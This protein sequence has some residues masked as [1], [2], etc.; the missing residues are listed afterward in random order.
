[1]RR[2]RPVNR[3]S[4]PLAVFLLMLWLP[5]VLLSAGR[6]GGCGIEYDNGQTNFRA[7]AG[8]AGGSAA[9]AEG[10]ETPGRRRAAPRS[11]RPAGL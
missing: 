3:R 7:P 6:L 2:F 4:R 1:M 8:D 9:D 11:P 10:A 5:A